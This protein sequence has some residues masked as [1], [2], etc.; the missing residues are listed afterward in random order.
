MGIDH[1][2][3]EYIVGA[4]LAEAREQ[5]RQQALLDWLRTTESQAPLS[6]AAPPSESRPSGLRGALRSVARIVRDRAVA[7]PA[8][9]P[10]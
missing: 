8:G 1:Y 4:R 7:S 3:L 9:R 5:Q 6:A 2:T 10:A